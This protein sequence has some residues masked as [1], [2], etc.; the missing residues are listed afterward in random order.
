MASCGRCGPRS[1]RADGEL[2]AAEVARLR[3]LIDASED[4]L[5]AAA[6]EA[7][8]EEDENFLLLVDQFEEIFRYRADHEDPRADAPD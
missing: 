3:V 1:W 6:R 8:L 4:G 2:P 7:G 5:A